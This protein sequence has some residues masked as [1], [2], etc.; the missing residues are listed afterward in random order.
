MYERNRDDG[1]RREQRYI[2]PNDLPKPRNREEAQAQLALCRA[3]ISGLERNLQHKT[4]DRFPSPVEYT[5]W[6]DNAKFAKD[7]WELRVKIVELA[8]EELATRDA[9]L[10]RVLDENRKLR[11]RLAAQ[12]QKAEERRSC[13]TLER[14]VTIAVLNG[15]APES[16]KAELLKALRV[17]V[18]DKFY[19]GWLAK[20]RAHN[21]VRRGPLGRFDKAKGQQA[22][23]SSETA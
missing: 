13:Q 2:R 18:S 21:W 22:K 3:Q 7:Q 12:Q 9:N 11:E 5:R 15:D 19:A 1:S 16:E 4:V 8:V 10:E 20:A 14:C 6:L 17:R 23:V